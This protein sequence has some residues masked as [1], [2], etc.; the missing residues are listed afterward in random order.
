MANILKVDSRG[1]TYDDLL[2]LQSNVNVATTQEGKVDGSAQYR[3]LG[4]GYITGMY[5]VDVT[6]LPK[7]LDNAKFV[8]TLQ[9]AKDTSFST[10]VNAAI[11]FL[12]NQASTPASA[13]NIDFGHAIASAGE[14]Q[15]GI[16]RYTVP[17]HNDFGGYIHRYVRHYITLGATPGTGVTH[18]AFIG[19][20]I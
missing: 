7:N 2:E 3:D 4:E 18:R 5:I 15:T 19:K 11:I 9:I 1:K 13:S 10:W 8:F 6:V 14:D 20:Q 17:F 12:G 16:G